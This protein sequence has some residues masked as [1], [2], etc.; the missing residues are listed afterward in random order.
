M[1]FTTVEVSLHNPEKPAECRAVNLLADSGAMYS[2]IPRQILD[3]LRIK[4]R[5]RRKFSLANGQKIER[6]GSG[7]LYRIGEYEGHAPVIFG[8]EGDHPILGVTALE[9]MG[10]QVDPV[11]QELKPTELLLL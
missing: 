3:D 10:L 9:A 5:W 7:A 2:I 11:S 6:D 1:G 4:P 8:E